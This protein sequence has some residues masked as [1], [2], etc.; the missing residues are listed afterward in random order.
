MKKTTFHL[1]GSPEVTSQNIDAA[2]KVY[3]SAEFVAHIK[4][5]SIDPNTGDPQSTTWIM[6]E[7]D[8]EFQIMVNDYVARL[9]AKKEAF[10]GK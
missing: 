10:N 3:S 4:V 9:V 5:L 6:D 8:P 1:P 2:R 7:N